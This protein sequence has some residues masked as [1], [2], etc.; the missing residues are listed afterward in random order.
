[1]NWPKQ[2]GVAVSVSLLQR[3]LKRDGMAFDEKNLCPSNGSV[4]DDQSIKSCGCFGSSCYLC[5]FNENLGETCFDFENAKEVVADYEDDEDEDDKDGEEDKN[6]DD[7]VLDRL[8][9]DPFELDIE[10]TLAAFSGWIEDFEWDF[11]PE[12]IEFVLGET[13]E[14][15]GDYDHLHLLGLG[16][17][18]N[19]PENLLPQGFS[20]KENEMSVSG[21]IFK[22][23]QNFDGVFSG[24]IVTEGSAGGF[25]RVKHDDYLVPS[26]EAMQNCPKIECDAERG[27]PHD[28]LF[29]VLGYLG[30][31]DLLSVEQVCRSLRDAVRGDP[32]LWRTVHINQ[33]LNE[34]ITDGKLVKLTNRAQGTLQ[35]LILVNCLWITDSGLQS[36]LQSNTGLM[37]L[38]V[39][40]CI[41]ITIEGILLN[42]RALKSSGKS[43][44][45]HL[46]IGGLGGMCHVT[47]Q[48]F[49]ELK[50]LL[51][52]SKHLQHG[53]R[54]PQFYR[55]EYSHILR[56]DGRQIDVDACPK[57]KKVRPIYDCPAESCQQKH[58]AAQLCRGCT[59][60]ITRCIR[61]GRCIK[62]IYEETF[63]L[64]ALCLNCFD[65]FLHCP[66][67][68]EKEAAECTI[69][70]ERT[71]YQFCLYG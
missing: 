37:K 40:D 48:Q 13:H 9:V 39:P 54:K 7:D 45:K 17:A 25:M 69:I 33:P 60:C 23:Y 36:V 62:D 66:V 3:S 19:G 8:P 38:S 6:N 50:E 43:G 15:I 64:E 47:E 5:C 65:Q 56:E 31:Q 20:Y 49:E 71:M 52:A 35:C 14:K 44:I 57:C 58:V 16:W 18:W 68:G 34:K 70:G 21:D 4:L 46:R 32:L 26:T 28:A 55:R 11:R 41:R 29:F 24:G 12:D 27:D 10:S 53:D 22:G 42:L 30:V 51:D 1:M 59:V 63:C 2:Y 61:C 67:E